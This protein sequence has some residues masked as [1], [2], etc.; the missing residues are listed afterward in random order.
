M[1]LVGEDQNE[2]R[3]LRTIQRPRVGGVAGNPAVHTPELDR[4]EN[5]P[6]RPSSQVRRPRELCWDSEWNGSTRSLPNAASRQS[7]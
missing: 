6:E 5:P 4:L 2:I 7:T 1:E 3:W